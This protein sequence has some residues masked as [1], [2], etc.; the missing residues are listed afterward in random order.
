MFISCLSPCGWCET[1]RVMVERAENIWA[2]SRIFRRLR[3][4]WLV[5][6]ICINRKGFILVFVNPYNHGPFRLTDPWDRLVRN[7]NCFYFCPANESGPII[8]FTGQWHY[9]ELPANGFL[10]YRE[11]LS[12]HSL[13]IINIFLYFCGIK[14]F[15]PDYEK[16]PLS[17]RY[18]PVCRDSA[19]RSGVCWQDRYGLRPCQ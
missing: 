14:Q 5:R 2:R 4:Q 15:T 11:T 16:I 9:Y 12:I 13:C 6:D 1:R 17:S 10:G 3:H 19:E 18:R 7:P 8:K